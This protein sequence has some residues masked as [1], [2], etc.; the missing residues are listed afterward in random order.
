[1]ENPR[2]A[3]KKVPYNRLVESLKAKLKEQAG[4]TRPARG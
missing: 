1:M 2:E 4:I 3:L